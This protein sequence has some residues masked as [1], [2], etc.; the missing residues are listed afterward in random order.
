M[1]PVQ[2]SQNPE[3]TFFQDPA[4]DRVLAMLMALSAEVWILNDR[5]KTIEAL[6]DKQ[7]VISRDD[8]ENYVPDAESSESIA[9]ERQ[10]FVR[11]LMEPLLG[12]EVTRGVPAS[13]LP[14]D[15]P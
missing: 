5:L 10:A 4:T 6:L 11:N 3:Q 15:T 14:G 13:L 12:R 8:L 9:A 7:G 1:K 2:P